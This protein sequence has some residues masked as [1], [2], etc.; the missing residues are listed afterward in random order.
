MSKAHP[1]DNLST[2]VYK[3][4]P[5]GTRR[6]IE[7]FD[8]ALDDLRSRFE[9]PVAGSRKVNMAYTCHKSKLAKEK[10]PVLLRFNS[11]ANK[12]TNP[13]TTKGTFSQYG[14]IILVIPVKKKELLRR[15]PCGISFI[16]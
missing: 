9:P 1:K 10:R 8:I 3:E 16:I 6:R 12:Q 15:L 2:E 7:R 14:K 4:D 11:L 13:V 5:P